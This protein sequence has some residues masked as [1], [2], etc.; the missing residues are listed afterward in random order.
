MN[1]SKPNIVLVVLDTARA[2]AFEPWGAAA[3]ATPTVAQL[4]ARGTAVDQAISTC[5]WTL[6]S[7]AAMFT[8]RLPRAVGLCGVPGA[9]PSG[10]R[11]VLEAN[12]HRLLAEVLRRAGYRTSG[13]SANACVSNAYGFDTGFDVFVD[14]RGHRNTGLDKRDWATKL[15]WLYEALAARVDDGA[16]A[17]TEVARGWLQERQRQPFFW[18][19]N[20]IECHSP[21]LPPRPWNDLGVLDRLRA[22]REARRHLTLEAIWRSTAC[23]E[24]APE[25]ALERMRRLYQKAVTL[26]DD[27][28]AQLLTLLDER[29]VLDDT[30][31]IVTSDH[32]E[33]LGEGGLLGHAFSLDQRLLHVP[34]V[35]AGPDGVQ[36]PSFFSTVD[37]PALIG[38]LAGLAANPW[39]TGPSG[40]GPSRIGPSDAAVGSIA[41][42]QYDAVVTPDDPRLDQVTRWWNLDGEA[43]DMFVQPMTAA[44]DGHR[45]LVRHGSRAWLY[46]LDSDPGEAFPIEIADPAATATDLWDAI[47]AADATDADPELIAALA[48]G[49]AGGMDDALAGQMRLLG[50][51]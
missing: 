10:V 33:N 9:D 36:I 12:R 46:D 17:S 20:L 6:P 25:E 28:L 43:R 22:T 1:A 42:A 48:A 32:G 49:S 21:Y 3:G 37:L 30:W 34:L 24:P 31:V 35:V 15:R 29:G 41:V 18:F 40:T 7:H 44:T 38:D 26:M 45:K 5:N 14:I 11:P 27:W 16:K 19:F 23:R 51:L 50:Y 4:A 47:R 2:S 8:G 39:R 13:A